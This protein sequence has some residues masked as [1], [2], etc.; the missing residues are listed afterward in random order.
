MPESYGDEIDVCKK[1]MADESV[2]MKSLEGFLLVLSNDGD[3]IYLSE[4]VSE[5]LGITQ[6]KLSIVN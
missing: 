1:T 5:Y 2:F 4:N 3:F 6:V